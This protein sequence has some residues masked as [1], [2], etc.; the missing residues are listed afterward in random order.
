[1]ARGSARA[2]SQSAYRGVVGRT[3]TAT[4]HV[5]TG[6]GDL[7]AAT[8]HTSVDAVADPELAQRLQ[9]D[10][11]TFNAVR[12]GDET[13]AVAVPVVYHDPAAELLVL[14]LADAYRHRELDE[15]IRLLEQLRDDGAAVP[16]Y[17]KDFGVVFDARGLRAYVEAR[18]EEAV[19]TRMADLERERELASRRAYPASR[20]R[21][22]SEPALEPRTPAAE[23][24][25]S[26]HDYTEVVARA[27]APDGANAVVADAAITSSP[28]AAVPYE[29][30]PSASSEPSSPVARPSPA[31]TYALTN[32]APDHGAADNGVRT[33]VIGVS[34]SVAPAARPT[35]EGEPTGQVAAH[36]G[37]NPLTTETDEVAAAGS[38]PWLDFAATGVTSSFH[39]DGG[40][41]RFALLAD[42]QLARGLGGPLEVR[43]LLHRAPTY[44]VVVLLI[45]P[46]SAM[47]AP[48]P[49]QLAVLALDVG[50]DL[51]RAVLSALAE[52][53]DLTVDVVVRG[54]PI[55]RV[56]LR[57]PLADNVTYILRAA[58][59]HLRAVSA[60]GEVEAS[61]TR[62]RALVLGADYDLL[63][64]EHA[65][66]GEFRDD[67]LAQ[68]AT[69]QH[70]RRALAVARHFVRPSRE[71]YLVCARGYPLSRWHELRRRALE[72]AVAW[73]IWMGPELAQVAVAEGLARSRRELVGKLDAGFD[74][75]R[76]DA[77]AFDLDGDAAADNWLAIA[78]E[79]R[80]QGVEVKQRANGAAIKSEDVPVVSGSIE[81]TPT[82]TLPRGGSVEELIALLDEKRHRVIAA[83]ELC[84]RG[85]P[86]AAAPVI[87]AVK[88][89]SRAEA[90]RILGKSVKFGAAAAA[91]LI[92]GLANSKG[93]LRHGCAL[94]LALLHTEEGAHAVIEL[95]VAE[96]TEIWREVA[97]A[98]GQIGPTALMPLAS[99]VGRTV[100]LPPA[101]GER[102]AWALAHVGVRGGKTALEQMATGSSVMAPLAQQALTL[103]DAAAHDE[104]RVRPGAEARDVTVN[105]AFS[106]RF[107]EA[108][109][110]DRPAVAR[111][112]LHELDRS[113]PQELEEADVIVDDDEAEL[114]E[115][116]LIQS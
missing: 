18:A 78:E 3:Q 21:L 56:R 28:I 94:A 112:A 57:A 66:Q 72:A 33:Q 76:H 10:D 46:P 95:L 15:R 38:D 102:V 111:A 89:M 13:I 2:P 31:R 55:R 20:T 68:L 108:L 41:V 47:R 59:D 4:V 98:I 91:P 62:A 26:T 39:V 52:T 53:F 79:A 74:V 115:S 43:V 113:R 36:T 23:P 69:A 49:A 25:V 7:I 106:R 81:R 58:D 105:R 42:D 34:P 27:L 75:L 16:R 32:G 6:G 101:I 107:F 64:R 5:T 24:L 44:P 109:E 65:E 100:P 86:R 96:P 84:D 37:G 40:Q 93:F 17:A 45:G 8:V 82:E 14:V 90:V 92:E 73:G 11:R 87:A 103:L 67:K 30:W 116:D 71:D 114:D 70:V 29:S 51:D 77:R 83:A 54:R 50:N 80:E 9:D 48:S 35:T 104:I 1:M 110:A 97:R 19:A 12:V 60:D 88:K 63:A 61:F 22:A 99:H 85:D